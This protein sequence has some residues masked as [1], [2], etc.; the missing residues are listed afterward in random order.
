MF[1]AYLDESADTGNAVF[2]VGGFAG[3]A[4]EWI[5]LEPMWLDALP[6]G[7]RYF[8][9][10][11]C[12]SRGGQ[13]KDIDIPERVALLG[14]LTDLVLQRDIRLVAGVM[15][16]PAYQA[17]SPKP[18]QNEF[19]GNKYAGA[20]GAPVE[21]AC[22]LMNKPG[23]PMPHEVDDI[24]A[25]FIEENEYTPSAFRMLENI[26][27]DKILWW[28]KRVGSM[29]AGTK[30]GPNAISMLQVADLGAFLAAKRVAQAPD[31]KIPWTKYYEKLEKGRRIFQ[32]IHVNE[33][34]IKLMKGL[35]ETLRREREEGKDYWDEV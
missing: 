8:H 25:F 4:E 5:A 2:A 10:T 20:F 33:R 3:R 14:R 17:I 31:G 16:V 7:I 34:S 1:R 15:D 23:E 18:L 28:R 6:E 27:N 12:F 24:C 9:A 19:L 11:D 13:F 26:R 32:I 35:D 30:S 29:T 21:C 22:Q